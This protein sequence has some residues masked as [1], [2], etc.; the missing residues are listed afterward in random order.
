LCPTDEPPS[1]L[2]SPASDLSPTASRK[3][4]GREELPDSSP[5]RQLLGFQTSRSADELQTRG[6]QSKYGIE[7][8][9]K[10]TSDHADT[11]SIKSAAP[12]VT[13]PDEIR[14]L[15]SHLLIS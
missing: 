12:E 3:K 14:Y 9:A 10:S 7:N 1:S 13:T 2:N 15:F 4:S 8:L 11:R 6:V 5:L